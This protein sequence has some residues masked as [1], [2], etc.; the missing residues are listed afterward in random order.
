M[1]LTAHM[2]LA[3]DPADEARIVAMLSGGLDGDEGASECIRYQPDF[4]LIREDHWEVHRTLEALAS[5]HPALAPVA[6]AIHGNKP[7]V[8]VGMAYQF[9]YTAEEMRE[10]ADAFARITPANIAA[11]IE[12]VRSEF[13][14]RRFEPMPAIIAEK[15]GILR[16]ETAKVADNG[17][18]MIGGMF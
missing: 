11:A 10:M 13:D 4:Q 3:F 8:E 2:A 5:N 7:V 15:I 12:D 18:A 9:L 6:T 16:D 14:P 1:G 17:W